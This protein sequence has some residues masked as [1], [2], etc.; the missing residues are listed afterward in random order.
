[1]STTQAQEEL[2]QTAAG[3][4]IEK[5]GPIETRDAAKDIYGPRQGY[6]GFGTWSQRIDENTIEKPDKWVQSFCV[7]CSAGCGCDIG[8][9]GEGKEAKIVGVRG[10]AA[11][12]ANKGRLGPKGM[13]S[14]WN[15][16]GH[17]DRLKYPQIRKNGKLERASWEEAMS[18]IVSKSKQVIDTLGNHGIGFYTS[19][20]LFLEEYYTLAVLGKA[21]LGS[22][23]MDGNTRLCTATAAA[24]M[25]ESFGSDGQPGSYTDIDTA[26]CIM[27]VGHNMAS[28]QTV[29]WSR[30]LDR[31]EGPNP[32]KI[33]VIDPRVSATATKA[34]IH[35]KLKSGT[36]VALLN[37]LQHLLI[38]NEQYDKEWTAKHTVGFDKLAETLKDCTPE[39]TSKITGIPA[40]T[41]I[42]AANMIGSVDRLMCTALQG[43]YQSNGATAAACQIN[44]IALFR[45][46]IGK[47]GGGVLQMN[48]Q[49]TAQ[50]NRECGCDGEFPGFRNPQNPRHM[51]ELA[52]HWN[53]DVD[54]LPH[55]NQT[56]HAAQMLNYL[57]SGSMG[58]FW[59]SGT[60]PAV[61]LQNS[62]RI[63]QIFTRED[64]F[65]VAQDIFPTETTALADVVLP[66]AM[67]GEK[68]GL[69]TNVDR[70]IHISYKAIDPPGEARPDMDIFVDYCKRMEFKDKDGADL[71][72]W[73]TPKE[74]FEYWKKSTRGT[75][76][77]VTGLTYEKLTGGSGIQWP[78]NELTSPYG[79]ERLYSDGKFPTG[80][81]D[82]QSFGHDL[83]TGMPYSLDDYRKID[84]NGRAFLKHC[85]Y[86]EP[87]ETVTEEYPFALST[88]RNVHH[89]H[90]RSKTGRS[91]K[92]MEAMPDCFAE[93]NREDAEAL[94]LK[95]FDEVKITSRRG[96]IQ[97]KCRFEG[98][99]GDI[100]KG[101]VF[102]P[103]H[104]GSFDNKSGKARAA[105][106]LTING[107]DFISKQPFFKSGAVKV[108]KADPNEISA[109]EL[110][111]EAI[112][113]A[114]AKKD[115]M[116]G[117]HAH[118]ERKRHLSDMLALWDKHVEGL[119]ELYAR[120]AK[121]SFSNY[122][123]ERGLSILGEQL[124]H[125]VKRMQPI[126]DKYLER[127]DV[128]Y[129]AENVKSI[130]NIL[131]PNT[132]GAT[133]FETLMDLHGLN[134]MISGLEGMLAAF[135]PTAGALMDTEFK[136]AVAE[137]SDL[138]ACH[139]KW[140]QEK[141]KTLAPQTLVV[142][143]WRSNQGPN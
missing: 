85:P 139:K 3:V 51:K 82:A 46:M 92:L 113:R 76:L 94:G 56:T 27:L 47:P 21:G 93:I 65:V 78:C 62:E 109:P 120:L 128:E 25:R 68:T 19:G 64:V 75:P 130:K 118:G 77:D 37:G 49:P 72:K 95:E 74:A 141:I 34:T 79:T 18:L 7:M 63:R 11:D 9:K 24:S 35:L 140:C 67:W 115:L 31:L 87:E 73:S 100:K 119:I 43:V 86:R 96:S 13:Y 2:A 123:I 112:G 90:T 39:W 117:L 50:N 131:F 133:A 60:N 20:Q 80:I 111:E 69:G 102:V 71:I 136:G 89:F 132:R 70:T 17:E 101:T 10:R 114:N 108:E 104:Y 14:S 126:V 107:W 116:D 66:A 8:V 137:A 16:I 124:E 12:R 40:E 33:V 23:H 32:P 83:D 52:E 42:A 45:G 53:I 110:Q 121:K 98:R 125:M 26:Q 29:L 129:A 59:I 138:V 54:R 1:M 105:N 99:W 58:M 55:W 48:G 57:E 81:D 103:F 15:A 97:V 134:M 6:N 143:S 41:I 5:D 36:N 30:I 106:E 84:P 4:V 22:L 28:T 91:K 88:G 142:P 127:D 135:V 38:K 44:N 61:S 122:E